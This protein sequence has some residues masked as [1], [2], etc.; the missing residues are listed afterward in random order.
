[1]P[2]LPGRLH[3]LFKVNSETAECV[4]CRKR[5]QIPGSVEDALNDRLSLLTPDFRYSSWGAP[6]GYC[7]VALKAYFNES[8]HRLNLAPLGL[9]S[10]EPGEIFML[11]EKTTPGVM[12]KYAPQ[13]VCLENALRVNTFGLDLLPYTAKEFI[14]YTTAMRIPDHGGFV[15]PRS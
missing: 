1:M 7:S 11:G 2:N 3:R 14:H 13:V 5:F 15:S 9:G 6:V 4:D 12:K 8:P 10:I